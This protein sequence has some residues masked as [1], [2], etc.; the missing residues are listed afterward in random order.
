MGYHSAGADQFVPAFAAWPLRYADR[1][2]R[3]RW[4]NG[5]P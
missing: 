3:P 1:V 4:R 2:R 5:Q